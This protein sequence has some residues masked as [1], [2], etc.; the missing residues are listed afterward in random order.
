MRRTSQCARVPQHPHAPPNAHERARRAHAACAPRPLRVRATR[1]NMARPWLILTRV[2]AGAQLEHPWRYDHDPWSPITAT[3]A[4]LPPQLP[5]MPTV[6]NSHKMLRCV[7]RCQKKTLPLQR[8]LANHSR[9]N[10]IRYD[11]TD[12]HGHDGCPHV[13]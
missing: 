12:L 4:T 1:C 10:Q 3:M 2:D 9:R 5:T 11:P 8:S 7:A 6:L 13:F